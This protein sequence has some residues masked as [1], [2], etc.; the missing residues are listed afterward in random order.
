MWRHLPSIR[1]HRKKGGRSNAGGAPS[2]S[3]HSPHGHNTKP[4]PRATAPERCSRRGWLCEERDREALVRSEEDAAAV[5]ATGT[6]RAARERRR[7]APESSRAAYVTTAGALQTAATRQ[8]GHRDT[9]QT[10]EWSECNWRRKETRS[11]GATHVQYF[12]SLL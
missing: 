4:A 11:Y 12:R 1:W 8:Y 7:T 6:P 3:A 10:R 9:T 2:R 5:R